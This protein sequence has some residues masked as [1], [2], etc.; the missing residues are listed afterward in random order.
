VGRLEKSAPNRRLKYYVNTRYRTMSVLVAFAEIPV[1][2]RILVRIA[3]LG[4]AKV[5]STVVRRNTARLPERLWKVSPFVAPRRVTSIAVRVKPS[6]WALERKTDSRHEIFSESLGA[7][8]AVARARPRSFGVASRRGRRAGGASLAI[9]R[10]SRSGGCCRRD[11]P[12]CPQ[13]L[14]RAAGGLGDCLAMERK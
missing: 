13:P 12:L 3:S 11:G 8:S 9:A 10:W 14:S 4:E 7:F 2:G 6:A 1:V 5:A